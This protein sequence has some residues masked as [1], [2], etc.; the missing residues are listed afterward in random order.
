[1][2]LELF[3]YCDLELDLHIKTWPTYMLKMRSN[4][5]KVIIQTT[6]KPTDASETETFTFPLFAPGKNMRGS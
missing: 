5:S 1:M 4:G 2:K 6:D 3:R